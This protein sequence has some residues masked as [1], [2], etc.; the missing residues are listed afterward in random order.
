MREAAG[1][2]QV[3]L[4]LRSGVAQPNIAAYET[5]RR[6]ASADMIERLRAAARPRPSEVLASHHDE[7]ELLANRFGLSNLRIFGSTARGGRQSG[8]RLGSIDYQSRWHRLADTCC[9]RG[10]GQ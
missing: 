9:V 4:S 10:R 6:R 3:E 7:L 2:S 5:G 1:L 8:K